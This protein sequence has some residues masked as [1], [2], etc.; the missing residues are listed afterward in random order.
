MARPTAPL[1]I[2]SSKKYIYAL[3]SKLRVWKMD[4]KNNKW[5]DVT[6]RFQTGAE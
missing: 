1:K 5:I 6:Y 4:S 2:L 3:D